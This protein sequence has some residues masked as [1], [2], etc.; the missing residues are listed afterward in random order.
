MTSTIL[1]IEHHDNPRD[2]LAATHLAD[3][4]FEIQL[5]A[6]FQGDCLPR[7]D[8]GYDQL[9][10]EKIA[11]IVIY[12]GS[13][14]LTELDKYAYLRDEIRWLEQA[15]S[16]DIPILGICLGAQMIAHCL[17]G[18]V[19]YH[20][21]GLCQFGYYPITPTA[22]GMEYLNQPMLVTQAHFQQFTL[23]KDATLLA[24]GDDFP[25]QAFRY[26]KHIFGLQF[27][28]E[29]SATIFN[30]WQ[31]A[32]WSNEFYATQGAQCV[33]QQNRV[34]AA[35]SAIQGAW[36]KRFLNTLFGMPPA[37]Y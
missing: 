28:A 16:T 35:A 6:P 7:L 14:N 36:F 34:M 23:P 1:L 5:I 8:E 31:T 32:P 29:V 21:Q 4:G 12:G 15:F 24:T 19:D 10:G 20:P 11:G 37:S 25:N 13:Q 2:D 22:A 3:C 30:R 17:G 33:D 18:C 26:R 9:S 27:H